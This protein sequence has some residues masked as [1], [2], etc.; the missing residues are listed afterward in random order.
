MLSSQKKGSVA[1]DSECVFTER[2]MEKGMSKE[3]T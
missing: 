3:A 2:E 1:N